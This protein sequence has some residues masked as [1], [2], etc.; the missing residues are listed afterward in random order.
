MP[1]GIGYCSAKGAIVTK[2]DVC[3]I[4]KRKEPEQIALKVY[5]Y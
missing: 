2:D 5:Y 1:E 3:E 4:F